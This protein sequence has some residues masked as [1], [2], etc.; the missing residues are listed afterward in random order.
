M[1][2]ETINPQ[3]LGNQ[4]FPSVPVDALPGERP[5]FSV[6]R[7]ILGYHPQTIDLTPDIDSPI[8]LTNPRPW[9]IVPMYF[10]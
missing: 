4:Q 3:G 6:I 5:V 8:H 2:I 7:T 10:G 9:P 1:G